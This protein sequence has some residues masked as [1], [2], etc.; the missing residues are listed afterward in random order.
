MYT[1]TGSRLTL[2]TTGGD[3]CD[4]QWHSI[5]LVQNGPQVTVSV[6]G[7]PSDIGSG[8]SSPLVI[9]SELFVGGVPDGSDAMDFV[10]DAGL[11]LQSG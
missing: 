11:T 10:G 7:G 6:L 3:L 1:G 4:G 8:I 9:T 2:S 5:T